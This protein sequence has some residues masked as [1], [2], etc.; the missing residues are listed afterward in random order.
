MWNKINTKKILSINIKYKKRSYG[1]KSFWVKYTEK[2]PSSILF[3]YLF[4]SNFRAQLEI[5]IEKVLHTINDDAEN[6]TSDS[7]EVRIIKKN[8]FSF[9]FY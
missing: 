1:K 5:A 6:T 3:R 2:N 9:V 8:S 4:F 7:E